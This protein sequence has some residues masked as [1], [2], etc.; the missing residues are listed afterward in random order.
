M[1]R[2]TG[3]IRKIDLNGKIVIPEE[4]INLVGISNGNVSADI[5]KGGLRI[6]TG[7]DIELSMEIKNH[8][9]IPAKLRQ[10]LKLHKGVIT[11]IYSDS[12]DN[13]LII[14]RA[15]DYLEV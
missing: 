8:I 2:F 1:V 3:L 4:L 13:S 14:I 15:N 6:G 5:I 10:I 7:K 12:E 9:L 11:K